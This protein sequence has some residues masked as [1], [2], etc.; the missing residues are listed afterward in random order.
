[1]NPRR[2]PDRSIQLNSRPLHLQVV[3]AIQEPAEDSITKLIQRAKPLQ[4]A[5]AEVTA[6]AST[7]ELATTLDL[8]P[9]D[10]VI[11]LEEV[12]FADGGLPFAWNTNSSSPTGSGSSCSG[13][14]HA[15]PRMRAPPA[16]PGHAEGAGPQ[17]SPRCGSRARLGAR[18]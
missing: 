16:Q 5:Q 8:R 7:P 1:M 3:R 11:V 10:P 14:S 18:P 17:R 4:Y 15:G 12:F 9:G 6:V 13:R 2:K